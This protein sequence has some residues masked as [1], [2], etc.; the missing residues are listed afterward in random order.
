VLPVIAGPDGV[1]PHVVPV[2]LREAKEV[3][4]A[5]LR[6]AFFIDLPPLRPT[7][8][9]AAA[10]ERAVDLLGRGGGRPRPFGEIPD[11]ER[12]YERYMAL[13][14]GD[15]GAAVARI[16]DDWGSKESPLRERLRSMTA[17]T[18]GELTALYEW[19][20][21]WRSRMLALYADHEAIVCPVNVGPA[22]RHGTFDRA[23]AA[24]TQVFN[25]TGWPS[26]VVRAGTSPEGL[27]IAVQ[28]VAP[29]WREDVSL[30]LAAYLEEAL[31]DFPG[32][33]L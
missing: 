28:V 29:P 20:D 15:G 3:T 25:L 27:P 1:D 18:S 12:L 23:T 10:V 24:Y 6:V 16:L 26:A 17:L 31:G 7:P 4:L 9:T 30:A 14:Y 32:P 11:A 21:R 13:L 33:I 22:P 2:P 19:L 5:G 8:Q